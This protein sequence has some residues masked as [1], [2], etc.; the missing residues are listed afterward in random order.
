MEGELFALA[1]LVFKVLMLGRHPFD[2]VGGESPVANIRKGV[3]PLWT[4]RWRHSQGA[5]VQH[6]E[7][8][9]LQA[10]GAIG[11]HLQEG[12]AESGRTHF[13]NGVDRPVQSIPTRDESRLARSADQAECAKAAGIPRHPVHFTADCRLSR[14]KLRHVLRCPFQSMNAA[15]V[16]TTQE[17]TMNTQ[18]NDL[19]DNPSPRCPVALVLD[20]SGSMSGEPINQLNA[21]AQLFIE[22][23]KRDDL[24]RW[25]VDL[26]VFTAGGRVDCLLD[27]TNVEQY[28]ALRL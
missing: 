24:A 9:A 4:G 27:F 7:P 20:V 3:F 8:S 21:G 10:Q 12:P 16:S 26:A 22:E 13:H 2:V 28:L 25:S 14:G 1:I 23:I 18:Y 5:M 11:A 15:T 19:I 17:M 6:L